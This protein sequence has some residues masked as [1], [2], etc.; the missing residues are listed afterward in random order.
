MTDIGLKVLDFLL[1]G[2]LGKWR[3]RK[4]LSGQLEALKRHILNVSLVNNYP[5]E[6]AKLRMFLLETGLVEKPQFKVF[7]QRWLSHPIV[8]DGRPV[9]GLFSNE[10]ITELHEELARLHL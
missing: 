10:Q 3:Q 5:I 1:G 2:L 4:A 8:A 9:L 6:L 7:F